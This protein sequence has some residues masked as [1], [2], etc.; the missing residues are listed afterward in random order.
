MKG[1]FM[2]ELIEIIQDKQGIRFDFFDTDIQRE[3]LQIFVEYLKNNKTIVCVYMQQ[4]MLQD[5][6]D[7]IEVIVN[8]NIELSGENFEQSFEIFSIS[9]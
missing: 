6:Y 4:K 5:E 1:S 2:K 3:Y 9:L 8:Q 7:L